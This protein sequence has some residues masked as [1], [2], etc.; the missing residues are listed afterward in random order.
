M[1]NLQKTGNIKI[2]QLRLNLPYENINEL[3]YFSLD[4][5]KEV[6][7]ANKVFYLSKIFSNVIESYGH[8]GYTSSYNFGGDEGQGTV[9][10]MWNESRKDMGISVDFTATGK[11]T[12]ETIASL[13]GINIDWQKLIKKV[14]LQYGGHISRIDIATDL[15]DYGFSVDEI[16]RRLLD[17]KYTF[18]NTIGNRIN[19]DRF[20][21][22]GNTREIQT[23]YVGSR[24]SDAFLRIYNKKV[25]QSRP[26][27]LYRSIASSCI[28]WIR[29]EA[30]F[31][32]RLAKEIG[33]YISSFEGIDIY[34]YLLSC[35]LE[36][37]SLVNE[38]NTGQ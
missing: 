32:H 21:I 19:P 6:Q 24:K 4:M 11:D 25:E 29:V 7:L 10:V 14:C 5:P 33:N 13:Y 9:S 12:Y 38:K 3:S 26:D 2:D 15:I 16:Y 30:E 28:D 18:L 36:R 35:V 31:K 22:Y 27:G 17:K 34:P 20:K 23:L 37:W 1:S 8:N